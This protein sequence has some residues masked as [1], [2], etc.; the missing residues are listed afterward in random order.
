MK[1]VSIQLPETVFAALGKEPNEFV[2]EMRLAAAVKWYELGKISHLKAAEI[3][4]LTGSEFI[5]ALLR[6]KVSPFEY[7][8]E[9]LAEELASTST[10]VE[11]QTKPSLRQIAALP[12]KERHKLL[13]QSIAATAEDFLNDP[14]L[15]EFSVLDGEDWDTG[16]D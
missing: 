9:K 15:T 14:D 8:V 11:P 16:N 12:I 5:D 2:Q 1:T 10:T 6:Y 3:A 13:A 7:S 4:G